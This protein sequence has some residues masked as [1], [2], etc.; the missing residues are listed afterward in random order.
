[1]KNDISFFTYEIVE[2][3]NAMTNV[4]KHAIR[5]ISSHPITGHK[6]QPNFSIKQFG[7]IQ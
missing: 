5:R 2:V 6:N 1:V 4:D 7:K 3:E